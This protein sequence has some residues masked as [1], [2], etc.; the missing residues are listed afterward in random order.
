[1]FMKLTLAKATTGLAG[2]S[3]RSHTA[4]VQ[5]GVE[6]NP[7]SFGQRMNKHPSLPLRWIRDGVPGIAYRVC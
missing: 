6:S 5:F 7:G 2:W 4:C 1:M 3:G